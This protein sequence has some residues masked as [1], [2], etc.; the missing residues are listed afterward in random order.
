VREI[1]TGFCA[2]I[3]E[4]VRRNTAP[5]VAGAAQLDRC[6]TAAQSTASSSPVLRVTRGNEF[7]MLAETESTYIPK[8]SRRQPENPDKAQYP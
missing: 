2:S 6:I 8:C 4:P 7:V 3:R 5:D 1:E